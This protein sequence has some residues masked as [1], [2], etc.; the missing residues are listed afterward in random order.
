MG[1]SHHAHSQL[2]RQVAIPFWI[3]LIASYVVIS[4][5][6]GLL[7]HSQNE[8]AKRS[9]T[10]LFSAT[11]T[12]GLEELSTLINEYGY[13]DEAV[14]HLVHRVDRTW[15]DGIFGSF[16][17]D[18]VGVNAFYVFDQDN[19]FVYGEFMGAEDTEDPIV[20]YRGGL[21]ELIASARE[22]ADD[23]PPIAVSGLLSR[24]TYLYLT[25]AIRMTTYDSVRD[26]S[27]DHVLVFARQIGPE[28]MDKLDRNYMLHDLRYDDRSPS[29]SQ[30]RFV[31]ATVDGTDG[32]SFIWEPTLPGNQQ[33]PVFIVGLAVLAVF[34]TVVSYFFFSRF[35]KISRKLAVARSVA[36][37]ANLAKSHF[38]A[39]MSHELRTPL[40]AILGF[41]EAMKLQINGPLGH[42]RYREY[43]DDIGT[44][45]R[46]LLELIEDILDLSKVEAGRINLHREI[47]DVGDVIRESCKFVRDAAREKEIDISILQDEDVPMLETDRRLVRQILLNLFSN[48]LKFT[49]RGGTVSCRV[50]RSERET[51]DIIIEDTG[52]GIDKDELESV[53]LPFVQGNSSEASGQ[54]GTGL[55]LPIAKKLS[56]LLGG[57]FDIESERGVGT[58]VVIS[59]PIL[60]SAETPPRSAEAA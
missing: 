11:L 55:G 1:N 34:L 2:L 16:F 15:I 40:N 37:D 52:V 59:L 13:W 38:L 25:A 48:A 31:P 6:I 17:N 29:Y 47:T 4:V 5:L 8:S 21:D 19:G 41:A 54:K 43:A 3:L 45:G 14:E 58:K 44:A 51:I 30:V 57:S 12:T 39:N 60:T 9:S 49:P 20:N 27:T 7:M 56:E 10:Q 26:I 46:H 42:P 24:S 53:L 32:P 22:S 36:E 28:M 23:A 18:D 33:L 50:A 35:G